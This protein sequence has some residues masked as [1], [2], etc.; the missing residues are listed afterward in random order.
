MLSV[1]FMENPPLI[2]ILYFHHKI[3]HS[4]IYSTSKIPIQYTQ[5]D[6]HATFVFTCMIV[7]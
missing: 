1:V 3:I 7:D 6:S 2:F 5:E 4:M